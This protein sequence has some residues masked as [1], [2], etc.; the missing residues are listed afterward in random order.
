MFTILDI[1]VLERE[2]KAKTTRIGT[3]E[4][5]FGL[6]ENGLLKQ[7]QRFV[8]SDVALNKKAVIKDLFAEIIEAVYI[9]EAISISPVG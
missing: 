2:L 4:E 6:M 3:L 9:I 8:L 7:K 5:Q 1:E